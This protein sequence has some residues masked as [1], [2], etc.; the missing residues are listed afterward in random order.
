MG[1]D[2]FC[3]VL[4]RP[5]V[6]SSFLLSVFTTVCFMCCTRFVF[7]FIFFCTFGFSAACF[8]CNSCFESGY[9][10]TTVR[11]KH[12]NVLVVSACCIEE[13]GPSASRLQA[14]VTDPEFL[15]FPVDTGV[16]MFVTG[17][18]SGELTSRKL[19]CPVLCPCPSVS[20]CWKRSLH[21]NCVRWARKMKDEEFWDIV[22]NSFP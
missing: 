12:G 16:Y 22:G 17:L 10:S 19:S 15:P 4:Y 14:Q 3:L 13:V 8:G 9:R 7:S 20:F 11:W 21:P 18:W 2:F 6:P 1:Y 5:Y